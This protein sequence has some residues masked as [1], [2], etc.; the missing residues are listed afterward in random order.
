MDKTGLTLD[1]QLDFLMQWVDQQLALGHVPR[2]SDVV[3]YAYT[4]ERWTHIPRKLITARLRLHPNY[5]MSA[6]QQRTRKRHGKY[7]PIITNTLGNLHC[8]LGFYSITDK[9]STPLT[10][11]AGFLVC[12]DVLSRFVYAVPL[13]KHK[14]AKSLINA[15]EKIFASHEKTFGVNGHKIQSISFDQERGIMSR[16]VQ[17]YL[18]QTKRLEFHDFRFSSSKAKFAESTIK[19]IRTTLARLVESLEDKRWWVHL[20]TVVHELNSRPIRIDGKKFDFSPREINK[21]TFLTFIGQLKKRVAKYYWCQFDIE[22]RL[23]NFKYSVGTL[24]RPKLIITSSAVIGIKR[25][26]VTLEKTIFV[27]EKQIAYISASFHVC[28]A[29]RCSR[30]D[31]SNEIEIFDE[32]DITETVAL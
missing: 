20:P 26:E 8:D 11:R 29:Y 25:S 31:N 16:Q 6:P 28:K 1:Q 9:Y 2:F 21:N 4:F 27:I 3:D 15:F 14:D 12:K 13:I 17:N 18:R 5:L 10:Y 7:R 32:D 30:I 24:V 23:V 22:P 19:Q